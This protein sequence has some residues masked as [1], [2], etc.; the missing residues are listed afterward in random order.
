MATRR[1]KKKSIRKKSLRKT[2]RRIGGGQTNSYSG[3]MATL[4]FGVNDR[5]KYLED[6]KTGL[7]TN[8][9]VKNINNELSDLRK[10]MKESPESDE[11]LDINYNSTF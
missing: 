6:K 11:N 7:L 10:K 4:G 5:I 8:R 1:Y 2:K 9:Q 3:I